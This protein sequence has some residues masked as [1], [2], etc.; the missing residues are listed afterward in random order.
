MYELD[1]DSVNFE[2]DAKSVVNS[3]NN[4]HPNDTDYGV[5]I[6]EYKRLLAILFWSSLVK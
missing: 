2:M 5:I 6:R 3:V 1:Y 4:Q